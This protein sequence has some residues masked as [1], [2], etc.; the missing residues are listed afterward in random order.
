M[1]GTK[2]RKEQR[3]KRAR[4]ETGAR[5]KREKRRKRKIGGNRQ[6]DSES[7]RGEEIE[8]K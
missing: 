1:E 3:G 4:R 2:K 5:H 8:N 7:E 6:G